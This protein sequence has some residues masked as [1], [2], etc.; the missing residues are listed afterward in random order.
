M[1]EDTHVLT[2]D[3]TNLELELS[4]Y[5]SDLAKK[6][7][8]AEKLNEQ[9]FS[10]FIQAPMTEL[11]TMYKDSLGDR[12][13]INNFVWFQTSIGHTELYDLQIAT[14]AMLD[15]QAKIALAEENEQETI[16]KNQNEFTKNQEEI[17]KLQ[18]QIG[19]V[20]N[21]I[22][23]SKIY[24]RKAGCLIMKTVSDVF[25]ERGDVLFEIA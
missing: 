23:T 12:E 21:Q 7:I 24:A 5:K 18:K 9:Y 3:T 22:A 10:E 2:L 13:R 8:Y 19:T 16:F 1:Q 17:T 6:N 4:K 25:V 14:A 11:K 20:L 15:I